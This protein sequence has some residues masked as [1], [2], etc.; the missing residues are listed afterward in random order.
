MAQPI[1]DPAICICNVLTPLANANAFI[2]A[3]PANVPAIAGLG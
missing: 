1:T 2:T 3:D